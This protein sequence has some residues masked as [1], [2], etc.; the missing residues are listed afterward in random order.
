[1]QIDATS[2]QT[3]IPTFQPAIF[4]PRTARSRATNIAGL[5]RRTMASIIDGVSLAATTAAVWIVASAYAGV[6]ERG[7]LPVT[8]VSVLTFLVA[9]AYFA[10]MESRRGQTIGKQIMRIRVV[11]A[12][13]APATRSQCWLRHAAWL[14]DGVA[15]VGLALEA[16][17]TRHQRLGA[18]LADT[19][20]I[21]A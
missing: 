8:I 11:A 12:D 7:L 3:T 14:C 21:N 10:E 5:N 17:S 18:M 16:R 9:F 19:V 15:F 4:M 6:T 2:F 13:G 1:M 20:V